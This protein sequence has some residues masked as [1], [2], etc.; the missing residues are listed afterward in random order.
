M[1]NNLSI[2]EILEWYVTAGVDETFGEVPFGLEA[3]KPKAEPAPRP[4]LTTRAEDSVAPRA[5]TT[6]LAQATISACKNARELCAEAQTLEELREMVEKFEGCALKL[7]ANKTVFGGGNPNSKIMLVGEAPGADEDRIGLP[8]VG[9]SGQLLD[10][11]LKAPEEI[12]VDKAKE[13]EAEMTAQS[14]VPAKAAK[15]SGSSHNR[16]PVA[17]NEALELVK[18]YNSFNGKTPNFLINKGLVVNID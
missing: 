16:Q 17:D 8:F 2:R 11:M 6:D 12:K 3:P 10:K 13:Q 5:A 14:A 4:V 15:T 9:R 18:K 7:T 1:E